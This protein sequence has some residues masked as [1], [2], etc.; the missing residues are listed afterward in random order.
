MTNSIEFKMTSTHY[1]PEEKMGSMNKVAES[2]DSFDKGNKV[3]GKS[4]ADCYR[5]GLSS[6]ALLGFNSLMFDL[7]SRFVGDATTSELWMTMLRRSYVVAR[8]KFAI[9]VCVRVQGRVTMT[10]CCA[11]TEY[12]QN[13]D[14]NDRCRAQLAVRNRGEAP[15]GR[16]PICKSVFQQ[17]SIQL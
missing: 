6:S 2:T 15:S 1:V 9:D 17:L 3:S 11:Q 5:C 14:F 7:M 16:S 13:T 4:A 12:L 8:N 10:W